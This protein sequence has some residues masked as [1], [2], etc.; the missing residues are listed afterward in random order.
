MNSGEPSKAL[1][2][3]KPRGCT[4]MAERLRVL[5]LIVG[6]GKGG[7]EI[8]LSRLVSAMDRGRF[9]NSVV[10]MTNSGPMAA[11][12]LS[13]GIGVSHLGMRA[14]VPD[15]AGLVRLRR[16]LMRLK[17]HVM[18]TW[19]YHANLLGLLAAWDL[20][21]T[22]LIWGMH[23][24]NLSWRMNKPLT[25]LVVRMCARLSHRRP[26]AIVCCSEAVRRAHGAAGYDSRKL[27]VIP[28]GYDTELFRP[29]DR[30]RVFLRHQLGIPQ[31]APVVSLIAR[32]HPQKDHETFI[33]AAAIVHRSRPDAHFILCG[34]GAVTQN[35][36][37]AD[38]IALAG[39]THSFH[40]LGPVDQ[41]QKVMAGS[42]VVASSSAG[43]GMSN[44]IG[45]AMACG[46]LCVATEAGD[47]ANVIGEAGKVVPAGDPNAL[48]LGLLS[49]IGL[50][51]EDRRRLAVAAR[52]RIEENFSL[53]RTVSAYQQLYERLSEKPA[54]SVTRA[55]A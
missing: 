15:P 3:A 41:V 50:D 47:S 24:S 38:W 35:K 52:R 1:A 32:F 10:S 39:S 42:T 7:A 22:S 33:K 53:S 13:A 25:L 12:L 37:L 29:D 43:E 51:Q 19:M 31:E 14:G 48:A 18:Q 45:E 36:V 30:A 28:N 55:I 44:V 5:H 40:L 27:L 26:Q 6:L 34:A 20:P 9:E 2:I 49:A 11:H 23:H 16:V 21:D 17:P 54:R 4:H 46:A 8:M